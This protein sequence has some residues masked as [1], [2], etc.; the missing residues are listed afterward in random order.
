MQRFLDCIAVLNLK[1]TCR[2]R[3]EGTCAACT[4]TDRYWTL[5]STSAPMQCSWS[6]ALTLGPSR[7]RVASKFQVALVPPSP[8]L[9]LA[10]QADSLHLN[11][12]THCVGTPSSVD[13]MSLPL[14][15]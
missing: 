5:V 12:W 3:V 1:L 6:H 7:L 2:Y 13:A 15:C 14:T 8:P 10:P 4:G 11:S 9:P